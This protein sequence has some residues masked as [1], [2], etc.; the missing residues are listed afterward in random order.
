MQMNIIKNETLIKRNARIAKYTMFAGLLVLAGGMFASF[1]FP[2]KV[3][4]SLGALMGG[5]LLSQIGIFFT[6]RWGRRPRPDEHLD[7]ALKGLDKKYTLFHYTT[8]VPH[9]L[10]GPA[11]LW[12]LL[13]FHQGGTITFEKGRWRQRGGNLYLKLFAQEGLGRPELEV[14]AGFER[15]HNYLEKKLAE[16]EMPT[17]QSALVFTNPKVVI[18]ISTEAN[19]PA[20]T[21]PV[22]KLKDLMRK[23]AK[24]KAL[25]TEK[26][27]MIQNIF[28]GNE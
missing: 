11:G 5:F 15:I 23:S 25:S 2:D 7:Q 10:V 20:E 4:I 13:P 16:D 21:L 17:I 19:T 9:L 24:G 28:E 6:N 12:I 8:P 3:Y 22:S 26:A 14:G 1:R 18:D 27:I